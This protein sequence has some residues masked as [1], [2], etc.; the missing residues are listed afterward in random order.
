MSGRVGALLLAALL[1]APL[2]ACSDDGPGEGEAR[3]EVDG[4]ATVTR[5]DGDQERVDDSTDLSPGDRVRVDEGVG[6]MRLHGGTTFELRAALDGSDADTEVV[7]GERP[8][9]E[10]GDL[11]VTTPGTAA[12]EA[13]GT[14]VDVIEGAARVSRAFG[15]SVSAYDADVEL[16]SAGATA[17]VRAL[18]R[19]T[20]PD[21]GQIPTNQRPVAYD[22]GDP[23]DVRHL[24]AAIGLGRDLER[25]ADDL[26]TNVLPQ[27]SGRTP[28]FFRLVL[29]ELEDEAEFEGTLLGRRDPRDTFIGAA[30]TVEGDRG[31]FLE[32]WR[33]VFDFRD[34]GAEWGIV[35]LDQDVEPDPLR[36]TIEEAFNAQF[37]EVVQGPVAVP[38]DTGG[39]D[40]GTTGGDGGGTD[41]TGTDGGAT[42]GTGG[43]TDGGDGSLTPTTEPPTT[44]T[45]PP[46]LPPPPEEEPEP[47]EEL[48]PVVEPVVDIVEDLLGG[49]LP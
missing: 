19:M 29:P 40:G 21:L 49:L 7:M 48:E 39:D 2:A 18:R 5:A 6:L 22:E 8:E 31:D 41:G 3:L 14:D 10:A 1:G 15:M 30:I 43:T 37:E 28:G 32:R 26:F 34:Q 44:P 11:L 33:D 38:P 46:L 13:D 36:G 25:L 9:L 47:T 45:V 42:D 16:D 17:E 27:G 24:G 23:W 35:V 12:L 20:V 4:V